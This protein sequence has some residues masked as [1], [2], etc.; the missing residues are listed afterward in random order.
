[1]LKH[2]LNGGDRA[3]RFGQVRRRFCLLSP[4]APL[5]RK[6]PVTS[7]GGRQ[8][9]DH[10]EINALIL[11][12]TWKFQKHFLLSDAKNQQVAASPLGRER[13]AL[14]AAAALNNC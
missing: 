12:N 10:T 5:H 3:Q 9:Q 6:K 14:E 2:T 7:Q 13:P 4:F 1:V 11:A 8:S